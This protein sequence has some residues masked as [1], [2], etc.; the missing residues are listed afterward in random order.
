MPSV[1]LHPQRRR[2]RV[3][4]R[5]RSG[6]RG[7]FVDQL[8]T[9]V[10]APA[11]A[12]SRTDTDV[13]N[14]GPRRHS[15]HGR[16]RGGPKARGFLR[17]SYVNRDDLVFTDGTIHFVNTRA[18]LLI[19]DRSADLHRQG[20]RDL[21]GRFAHAT[22]SF[23][24]VLAA[25]V[26]APRNPDGTCDMQSLPLFEVDVSGTGSLSTQQAAQIRYQAKSLNRLE[27]KLAMAASSEAWMEIISARRL[28]SA[29]RERIPG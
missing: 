25:S 19:H 22:G 28:S 3:R 11:A 17:G 24:G 18:N 26:L 27:S 7:A 6:R 2:F 1:K 5:A 9:T 4:L 12:P 15:A 13:R 21:V 29:R 14:P 10:A 8:Y 23:A 16:Q 20:E